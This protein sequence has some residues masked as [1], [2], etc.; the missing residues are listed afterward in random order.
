MLGT[1]SLALV[2]CGSENVKR[3]EKFV[4]TLASSESS[5]SENTPTPT[6]TPVVVQ[7]VSPVKKPERRYFDPVKINMPGVKPD[8]PVKKGEWKNDTLDVP[9]GG[10]IIDFSRTM[11]VG[12][13]TLLL[14]GHSRW[15]RNPCPMG[16]TFD[17]LR[18]DMIT[19]LDE[20]DKVSVFEVKKRL[21]L[22]WSQTVNGLIFPDKE[23]GTIITFTTLRTDEREGYS[24]ILPMSV[25]L[26]NADNPGNIPQLYNGPEYLYWA[27]VATQVEYAQPP[28][29]F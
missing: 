8:F 28:E 16:A 11:H 18:G 6:G 17:F 1:A 21:A 25:A 23:D 5:R 15:N 13:N 9:P 7:E 27:T 2:G 22:D 26:R 3:N 20:E 4:P 10:D 29:I 12:N 19:I 14:A 24:Q